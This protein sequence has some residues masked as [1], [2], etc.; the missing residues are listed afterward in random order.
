MRVKALYGAALA[1]FVAATA[2]GGQSSQLPQERRLTKKNLQKRLAA[3]ENPGLIIG[4]FALAD[5][6]VVDGDTVHV[7]GLGSSLRLLGVDAEE[8]FKYEKER[9]AYEAGWEKYMRDMRGSSPKPVKFATPMGDEAKKWAQKFYADVNTVRLERDHPKEVRDYYN[10]YL[11]YVIVD[12]GGGKE[13]NYNIEVVRAGYSPYFSKY[14]YSRRFHQQ[15]VDAENEARAAGRG[16]WD[17]TK[18]HYPDYD[19]RK[20]WWDARAEF[21]KAFEDEAQAHDNY[22]VLTNYDTPTRLEALVGKEVVVLGAVSEV[23]LG[24]GNAPTRVLLSRR[25]TS[26]FPLIFWDR[27]VYM[28]S[29][30]GQ[31]VGDYIKVKGFVTK[32]DDK[33][34]HSYQL[35]IKIDLP[36]QIFAAPKTTDA[37]SR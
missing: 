13:E 3:F 9:R 32:Y 27:D 31:H 23:R 14:G 26:D 4:E 12:R 16:I 30:V 24:D 11:A 20:I 6:S 35:Q 5:K 25:R 37:A 29:G 19:E 33:R 21:I 22:I 17:P 15:F 2:C 7:Q 34:G 8:T 10:R 28:S 36:S 1:V 18:Q